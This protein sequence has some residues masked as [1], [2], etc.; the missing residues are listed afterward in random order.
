VFLIFF[1]FSQ[2]KILLYKQGQNDPSGNRDIVPGNLMS[3]VGFRQVFMNRYLLQKIDKTKTEF[4]FVHVNL[5]Y[6]SVFAFIKYEYE[7]N[8][9]V[10][11]LNS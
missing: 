5:N 3:F 10:K 7:Q 4:I 6:I 8:C 9:F 11:N 1:T 2:I